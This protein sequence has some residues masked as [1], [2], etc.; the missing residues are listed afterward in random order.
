MHLASSL[1]PKKLVR[2]LQLQHIDL[3]VKCTSV[4]HV[5]GRIF[6]SSKRYWPCLTQNPQSY[7][8]DLRT[9]M[10]ETLSD[11]QLTKEMDK[12]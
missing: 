12:T 4:L 8:Q 6:L 1:A 7:K 11:Q 3:H 2:T 10:I 5:E 9:H